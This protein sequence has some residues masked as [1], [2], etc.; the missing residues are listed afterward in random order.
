[1]ISEQETPPPPETTQETKPPQP[2]PPFFDRKEGRIL[3]YSA[4][5]LFGLCLL[6][7]AVFYLKFV[8]GINRRLEAGPFAGTVN[9]FSSPRSVA[10]G[11]SLTRDEMI[12]RLQRAGYSTARG[13][14]VGWF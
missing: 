2:R 9:I 8:P 5:G 10:V 6:V 3:L 4:M 7:F 1:M 11:D 12:A 14:T 13:N